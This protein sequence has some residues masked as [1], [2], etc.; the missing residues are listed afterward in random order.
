MTPVS[1]RKMAKASWVIFLVAVIGN[2]LLAR[3]GMRV[4]NELLALL[5]AI[6]GFVFAIASLIL[7]A[8]VGRKGILAPALIGLILNG[9]LLTIWIT[10]FLHARA[11]A[12]T[13]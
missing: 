6:T 7:I 3:V 12:E 4:L 1:V 9:L 8:K 2:A 11:V 5:L 13:A 10:N